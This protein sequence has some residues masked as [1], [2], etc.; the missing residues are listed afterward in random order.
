M[1]DF[2]YAYDIYVRDIYA[3]DTVIARKMLRL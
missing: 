2:R 3:Y 1:R